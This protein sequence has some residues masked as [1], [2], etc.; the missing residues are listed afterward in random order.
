MTSVQRVARATE[1]AVG[2]AVLAVF[3][4]WFNARVFWCTEHC[5]LVDFAM[6][7]VLVAVTSLAALLLQQVRKAGGMKCLDDE[8][9]RKAKRTLWFYVIAMA[10]MFVFIALGPLSLLFFL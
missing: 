3:I 1:A 5:G 7:T 4:F 8:C 6:N 10:A 9:K 2:A